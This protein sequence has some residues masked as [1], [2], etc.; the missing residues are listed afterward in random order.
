MKSVIHRVYS[1]AQPIFK[2]K[3]STPNFDPKCTRKYGPTM[4]MIGSFQE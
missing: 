1:I 2:N 4:E 3:T